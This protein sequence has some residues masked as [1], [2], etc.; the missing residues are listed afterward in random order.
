MVVGIIARGL[1]EV[2]R[3]YG[4][5]AWSSTAKAIA[6]YDVKIFRGLY[7][8]TGGRAVRHGRDAGSIIAGLYQ[9]TRGDDLDRGSS[10]EPQYS[11]RSKSEARGRRGYKYGSRRPKCR[12]N[13]RSKRQSRFR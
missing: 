6:R 10:Y 13:Y 11:S 2:A 5:R 3:Y 4:P 7:G 8:P 1:S 12:P 9:G